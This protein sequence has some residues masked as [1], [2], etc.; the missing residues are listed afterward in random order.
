V[1]SLQAQ[2]AA[3]LEAKAQPEANPEAEAHRRAALRCPRPAWGPRP[4]APPLL[5]LLLLLHVG[6]GR[7]SNVQVTSTAPL[8]SRRRVGIVRTGV[9][10]SPLRTAFASGN[11]R[12]VDKH[13]AFTG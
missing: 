4:L 3:P 6:T 2:L 10:C 1:A 12:C 7:A 13:T 11:H 8:L 9:L 5:L